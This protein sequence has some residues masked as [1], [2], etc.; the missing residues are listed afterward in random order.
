[1]GASILTAIAMVPLLVAAIA[2]VA[3]GD[4]FVERLG[5]GAPFTYLMRWGF[6]AV[7][8]LTV[9]WLLLR[10]TPAARPCA[11]WISA[12]SG[13]VVVGWLV[14]AALYSFYLKHVANYETV[15]GNLASAFV[16]LSFFY[17]LAVVFLGGVQVDAMLRHRH[18]E[19]PPGD[20]GA[21]GHAAVVAHDSR[22][23]R[24]AK[25]AEETGE[26]VGVAR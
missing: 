4:D 19:G 10:F 22:F 16:L 17:L 25:E 9:V 26:P 5:L 3:F 1:V 18:A 11:R 2:C 6:S 13:L 15:F 7:F 14:T 12:G 21:N 24:D 8:L 23:A 20:P